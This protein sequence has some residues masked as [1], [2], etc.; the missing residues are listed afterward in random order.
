M[1]SSCGSNVLSN[2][3]FD[4]VLGNDTARHGEAD[5]P[6]NYQNE[7]TP[8]YWPYSGTLYQLGLLVREY[9]I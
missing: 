5:H 7:V 8:F 9:V 6:Y 3:Y 2:W 1:I 4:S